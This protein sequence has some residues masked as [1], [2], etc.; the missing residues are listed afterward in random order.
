MDTIDIQINNNIDTSNFEIIEQIEFNTYNLIHTFG[1]PVNNMYKL[2]VN[3]NGYL[4]YQNII[5]IDCKWIL[6]GNGND[7][8]IIY[9]YI[10]YY[11]DNVIS[12][13]NF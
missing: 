2:Q 5:A 10:K 13:Y 12:E 4:I 8:S 7:K 11:C 3:G 6:S 9:D 1:Y